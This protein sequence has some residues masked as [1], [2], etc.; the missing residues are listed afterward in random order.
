MAR[1]QK[2]KINV[3]LL[4]K[5]IR[6]IENGNFNQAKI[7]KFVMGKCSTYYSEMLKNGTIAEEVLDRVCEYYDLTKKDYIITEEDVQKEIQQKADTQNYEN[8]IVLLTGI[9]KA[10]KEILAQQKS[11][12]F[13]LGELKTNAANDNKFSKEI[14]QKLENLEKRQRYGKYN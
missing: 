1:P 14:I 6:A 10:L 7:S 2:I 3:A 4:D 13:L 5:N 8:L 12:N 9:D 11:T